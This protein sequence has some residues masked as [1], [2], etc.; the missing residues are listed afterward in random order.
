MLQQWQGSDDGPHSRQSEDEWR[1]KKGSCG[2]CWA[3]VMCHW[4]SLSQ[5]FCHA[6][7]LGL[8]FKTLMENVYVSVKGRGQET[9]VGFTTQCRLYVVKSTITYA[10]DRENNGITMQNLTSYIA[11]K[12]NWKCSFIDELLN[13]QSGNLS[14]WC[15]V[16]LF[17][18]IVQY[19]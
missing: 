8:L 15:V 3:V 10:E 7:L 19:Y 1:G 17:W 14:G 4:S 13:Q 12:T 16:A 9:L 5:A 2:D 18:L 11:V 6:N